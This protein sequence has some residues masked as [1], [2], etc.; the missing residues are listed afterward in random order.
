MPGLRT[1]PD[2]R[3]A[4]LPTTLRVAIGLILLEAAALVVAALVLTVLAFVH[5]TTE[6]WAAFAIIGFALLAA[7]VLAL[8]A[9][10]L[11]R[12]RPSSRTPVLFIQLLAL[13]VTY[14]LGFQAGRLAIA[15][16]IMAVALVVIGLL[17]TGSARRML[18]RVV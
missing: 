7:A 1:V 5:D 2:E 13:P 16:P 12:L 11:R 14:S 3:V 18:D 4:D 6:L 10:G 9:R 15:L 8:C 17:M